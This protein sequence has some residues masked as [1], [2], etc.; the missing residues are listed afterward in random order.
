MSRIKSILKFITRRRRGTDPE[1]EQSV[2]RVSIV[3]VMVIYLAG[4]QFVDP[5]PGHAMA[6]YSVACFLAFSFAIF[7]WVVAGPPDVR[8][9]KIVGMLHDIG[10]LTCVMYFF[11]AATA[12]FYIAFLWVIFGNGFRYG[13]SYL[14][15]ASAMSTV[16][17]GIVV[18]FN[19][20]MWARS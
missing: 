16:G 14:A 11:D 6:L 10:G 19:P 17:F 12:P 2:L 5:T 8:V 7:A 9:R 15:L 4:R 1:L 20:S 18:A 13:T 3:S